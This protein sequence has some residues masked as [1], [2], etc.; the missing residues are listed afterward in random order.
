[1]H[2]IALII[3]EDGIS[4][5]LLSII[6]SL[7]GNIFKYDG[8]RYSNDFQYLLIKLHIVD[9]NWYFD[10]YKYLLSSIPGS[11]YL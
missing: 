2:N 10:K 7:S 1:M 4:D 3:L 11:I 5:K 9:I 6:N 8:L